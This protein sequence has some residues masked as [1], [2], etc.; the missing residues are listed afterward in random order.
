MAVASSDEIGV[1]TF[2]EHACSILYNIHSLHVDDIEFLRSPFA[3]Q[4]IKPLR[5]TLLSDL[6]ST[7]NIVA[8]LRRGVR[9]YLLTLLSLKIAS[10][11]CDGPVP[12]GGFGVDGRYGVA[13]SDSTHTPHSSSFG[14]TPNGPQH[15]RM[16]IAVFAFA[17]CTDWVRCF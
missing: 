5:I 13:P 2:D 11:E 6:D 1:P 8:A 4:G 9:G 7:E 16:V 10:G 15:C 14:R 17:Q 12:K 3:M